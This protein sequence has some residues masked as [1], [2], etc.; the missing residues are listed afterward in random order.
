ME[1]VELSAEICQGMVEM[2]EGLQDELIPWQERQRIASSLIEAIVID[3]PSPLAISL[4][5]EP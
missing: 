3:R 4:R 1:P 2:L 5:E